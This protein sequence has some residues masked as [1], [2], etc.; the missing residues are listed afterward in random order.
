MPL[1]PDDTTLAVVPQELLDILRHAAEQ[2]AR[3]IEARTVLVVTRAYRDG[4]GDGYLTRDREFADRIPLRTL[5][6]FRT[7]PNATER[8]DDASSGDLH[9]RVGTNPGSDYSPQTN[10]KGGDDA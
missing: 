8:Y 5:A 3:D 9:P 10:A 7:A 6:A 4:W 2:A 1:D